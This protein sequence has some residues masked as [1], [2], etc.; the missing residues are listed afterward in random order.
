VAF[1]YNSRNYF[2]IASS[3]EENDD[4]RLSFRQQKLLSTFGPS[5]LTS[6]K[7]EPSRHVGI[8]SSRS[9]WINHWTCPG[10]IFCLRKPHPFGNEYHTA[11]CALSGIMFAVGLVEGKDAPPQIKVP[12]AK[13]SGQ[14]NRPPPADALDGLLDR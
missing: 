9:G 8:T 7:Y 3:A 10:W 5:N 14:D 1:L 2:S 12:H 4:N 6:L 13:S 11:C